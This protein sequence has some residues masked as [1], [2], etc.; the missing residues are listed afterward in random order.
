MLVLSDLDASR[1]FAPDR[2]RVLRE[3][4]IRA[5]VADPGQQAT[6]LSI[7][8]TGDD[9]ASLQN[10]LIRVLL[11]DGDPIGFGMA[12]LETTPRL[13]ALYIHPDF[14]R[15]GYG[16]KILTALSADLMATGAATVATAAAAP[17][18]PFYLALG[19]QRRFSYSAS[20]T[21][22]EQ[23]PRMYFHHMTAPIPALGFIS[24]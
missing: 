15:R 24:T 10:V 1:R 18:Q 14:Q 4:A 9:L 20:P 8:E 19:F 13:T 11:L 16:R 17:A 21:G 3:Y 23:G 22:W 7:E 6:W 12:Q 5:A 2:L